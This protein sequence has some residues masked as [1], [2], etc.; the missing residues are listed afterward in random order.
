VK[1][2][3][4]SNLIR[5]TFPKVRRYTKDG[6]VYY[7][8]LA[9]SKKLGINEHAT[10]ASKK[11]ALDYAQEIADRVAL[12]ESM[13]KDEQRLYMHYR[14][15]FK[16]F[17]T[18]IERVLAEKL[19]RLQTNE[20]E[21]EQKIVLTS[22]AIDEYEKEK[23]T[24][25][26]YD[27]RKETLREVKGT[28]KA[29]RENWGNLPLFRIKESAVEKFI[30]TRKAKNGGPPTKVTKRNWKVRISAF[31]NWCIKK[32]YCQANPTARL[33]YKARP[34]DI[35]IISLDEV[36]LML[37]I[38]QENERYKGLINYIAI[39]FFAGLRPE[40]LGRLEW[41]NIRIEGEQPTIFVPYDTSKVGA[42]RSVAIYDTLYRFLKKYENEAIRGP[43][44]T[45][46]FGEVKMKLGYALRKQPGRRWI[47]DG[48]RHTFA[49]MH[50]AKYR[51]E[52]ELATMMGNSVDVI[53]DHYKKTLDPLLAEEFW[54]IKPLED[55]DAKPELI[56]EKI[57]TNEK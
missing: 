17:S 26:F 8:I 42:S 35:Q 11:E 33:I 3:K 30:E 32:N 57:E 10:R 25:K 44:F 48:I 45:K 16:K 6:K 53:R 40:E 51:N 31:F 1:K 19:A 15:Q 38:V 13:T 43:N 22:V 9:R 23:L 4:K 34:G 56:E 20:D 47:P 54:K 41:E 14:E 46:L 52:E 7:H 5:A 49:S 18:E 29:V 55:V 21:G 36:K 27:Y 2:T 50:V 39:G 37:K 12:G 24:K 28:A